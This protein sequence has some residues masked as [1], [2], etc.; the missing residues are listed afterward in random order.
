MLGA[1]IL[2]GNCPGSIIWGQ[3]SQVGIML[4]GGGGE[5]NCPRWELYGGNCP[6][7]GG[8]CPVPL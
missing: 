2:E 3:I 4:G 5:G 6:G 8:D 7:G 1:I